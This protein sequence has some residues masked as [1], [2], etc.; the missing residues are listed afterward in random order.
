MPYFTEIP[1]VIYPNLES[2]D[3]SQSVQ[4]TN[5]L[6]RSAFL[7]EIVENTSLFYEYQVK[8]GETAEI[9]AD[10]LYGDPNHAW[11]VLLF[12]DLMNPY[13]DFPLIQEQLH[14][15]IEAK[16]GQTIA[17]SQTTIHHY[18]E[19]IKRTTYYLDMV[20]TVTEDRYTISAQYLNPNTGIVENR[21]SLPGTADTSIVGASYT[22]DFGSGV[23]VI[24]ETTYHAISNYAYELDANEARRNI[25]LLD[26]S[27][28]GAVQTEFRRLMRDGR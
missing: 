5:I 3:P 25:T 21:P 6:T 11:I 9:I 23:K 20:Q 14:D 15:M 26:P 16:Y 24:V 13:Y 2:G 7:R 12:N 22:E 8:D 10:K 1:R 18:E 19:R 28:I 27:Y 17:Q 4:L